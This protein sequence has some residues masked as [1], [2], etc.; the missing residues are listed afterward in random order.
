[1]IRKMLNVKSAVILCAFDE[2]RI[3]LKPYSDRNEIRSVFGCLTMPSAAAS[4]A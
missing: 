1:M 4:Q 3:M 2:Y